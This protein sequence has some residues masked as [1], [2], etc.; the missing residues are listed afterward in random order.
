MKSINP[1]LTFNGN[2][3][4]AFNFYKEVF[5]SEFQHIGR[6]GDM[7]EDSEYKMTDADKKK[8]MHVSLPLKKGY[9]LMGSDT[10]DH[11]GKTTIEIVM[12]LKLHLIFLLL[13]KN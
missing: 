4:A 10:S 7:P 3:E 9:T 1:Y 8:I 6:F 12:I 13:S 11:Y 2:C 5:N